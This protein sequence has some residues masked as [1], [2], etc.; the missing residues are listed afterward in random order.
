MPRS[1]PMDELA[2]SAGNILVGNPRTTEGLE[3]IVVPGFGLSLQ[4]FVAAVVS[5]TGKNVSVKVNGLEMPLWSRTVVPA[6]AKLELQ[7]RSLSD[8]ATGLRTYLCIHGGFPH[9]PAYLGSK[10]TSMGL[11]CYQVSSF[12]LVIYTVSLM[13]PIGSLFDEGRCNTAE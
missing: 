9:I 2:F 11:G 7:A 12:S 1:G 3:I 6:N 4:F 13:V 5:V 10:S 8:S